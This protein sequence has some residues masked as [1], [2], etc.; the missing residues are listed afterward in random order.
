V[1]GVDG[2]LPFGKRLHV[3][4]GLADGRELLGGVAACDERAVGLLLGELARADVGIEPQQI[5]APPRRRSRC[6]SAASRAQCRA[7]LRRT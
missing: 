2:G 3:G 4:T 1:A 6:S 7:V 5:G